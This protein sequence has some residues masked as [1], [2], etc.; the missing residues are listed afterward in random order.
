MKKIVWSLLL[1]LSVMLFSGCSAK[2][3]DFTGK[4]TFTCTHDDTSTDSST[5]SIIT[6]SYDDKENLELFEMKSISTF[7]SDYAADLMYNLLSPISITAKRSGV[8]IETKKENTT[9]T[10]ITGGSF[11]K[12]AS[13]I[14]KMNGINGIE[15][16]EV[17]NSTKSEA[18]SSFTESGYVCKD[19]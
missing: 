14:S 9:V 15:I 13:I 4:K 6:F 16:E 1:V 8:Y 5:T 18:I 7:S 3:V 10:L 19:N 17:P 2:P 11:S 12:F